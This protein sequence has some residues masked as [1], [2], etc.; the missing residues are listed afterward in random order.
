MLQ[1]DDGMFYSYF[2]SNEELAKFLDEFGVDRA[3]DCTL[4]GDTFTRDGYR[5]TIQ[6]WQFTDAS[7]YR[8]RVAL[9]R[10]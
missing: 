8:W 10:N 9:R 2:K 4:D 6:W 1:Y 3:V 5:I 7:E